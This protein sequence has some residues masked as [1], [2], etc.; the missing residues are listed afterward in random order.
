MVHP[1]EQ[2]ILNWIKKL[3]IERDSEYLGYRLKYGR[4]KNCTLHDVFQTKQGIGYIMWLKA[5]TQS[6]HFKQILSLA[7]IEELNL[8]V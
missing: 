1:K 6:T 7:A 3:K 4:F 5:H 2:I 8:I